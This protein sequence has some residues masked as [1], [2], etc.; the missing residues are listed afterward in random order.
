MIWGNV[1][2]RKYFSE[3]A[4]ISA[5]Q[6]LSA[7]LVKGALKDSYRTSLSVRARLDTIFRTPGSGMIYCL[8]PIII[9]VLSFAVEFKPLPLPIF[10]STL[11]CAVTGS[12]LLASL[13]VLPMADVAG[14]VL[15]VVAGICA[16]AEGLGENDRQASRL[17]TRVT[18][19]KPSMLAIKQGTK[20]ASSESL[21]Q[22]LAT[23]EE[24]QKFMDKYTRTNLLNR[25]RKQ[26]AHA[27]SIMQLGNDVR[28]ILQ[29]LEL[30]VAVD[31]EAWARED[32]ADRVEEFETLL[33]VMDRVERS[34]T[35]D[36]KELMRLLEVSSGRSSSKVFG[37]QP[38]PQWFFNRHTLLPLSSVCGFLASVKPF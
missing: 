33:E 22:L 30:G 38:A 20:L 7:C 9:R 13:T 35:R 24:I 21:R 14:A 11:V 37:V 23:V 34:R 15:R 3:F 6:P 31:A 18:A 12:A 29:T 28:D 10:F 2:A 32:A 5:E 19:I 8:L 26:K 4:T 17:V 25:V 36:H 1:S 16:I 27:E